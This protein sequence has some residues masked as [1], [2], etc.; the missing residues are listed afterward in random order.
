MKVTPLARRPCQIQPN[1]NDSIIDFATND[2]VTFRHTCSGPPFLRQ[3]EEIEASSSSD[4]ENDRD[5]LEADKSE[6]DD[7]D[8]PLAT[9]S[10]PGRHA[11]SHA[12][13]ASFSVDQD[14]DLPSSG[15]L[16]LVSDSKDSHPEVIEDTDDEEDTQAHRM[17]R[18]RSEVNSD[19]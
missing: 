11:G 10:G 13:L 15:L 8:S 19:W 7:L 14:I 1:K 4:D 12:K 9:T 2:N 6:L 18:K 17:K 16:D 3:L 5:N